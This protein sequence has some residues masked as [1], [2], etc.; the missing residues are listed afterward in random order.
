MK[1]HGQDDQTQELKSFV[2]IAKITHLRSADRSYWVGRSMGY[3]LENVDYTQ[4]SHPF[5]N[6]FSIEECAEL[7]NITK[8]QLRNSSILP[9]SSSTAHN[10][11]LVQVHQAELIL[12]RQQQVDD[13]QSEIA[14]LRTLHMVELSVLKGQVETT[15]QQYEASLAGKLAEQEVRL[16]REFGQREAQYSEETIEAEVARRVAAKEEE[17]VK[18]IK[19]LFFPT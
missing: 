4:R 16:K 1:D 13:N 17:V 2:A 10:E 5:L 19:D 9:S 3:T 12:Q 15:M 8:E 6:T 14:R 11:V 7:S 18:K